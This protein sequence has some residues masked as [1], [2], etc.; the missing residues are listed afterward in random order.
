MSFRGTIGVLV[1]ALAALAGFASAEPVYLTA[2]ASVVGLAPFYSDVRAFNTSYPASLD[3]TADYRCFIGACQPSV[4]SFTLA[5]RESRAFD[6]V[7]VSLFGQPN[8]AG[9]I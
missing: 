7:C 8:T 6:D 1:L 5:P 9:A 2:A 3:V 4:Q